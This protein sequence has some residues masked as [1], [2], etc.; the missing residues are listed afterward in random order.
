MLLTEISN[1]EI[2]KIFRNNQ[3]KKDYL[4][5]LFTLK[6]LGTPLKRNFDQ[7]IIDTWEYDI[8]KQVIRDM[9]KE[10]D[11]YQRCLE[12]KVLLDDAL[13]EW[14][15]LDLGT[16]EWPFA[17]A[18]FDGHVHSLNRNTELSELE[19]DEVLKSEIVKF[20]RIKKISELRN[21][22]IEYLIFQNEN[23]IP[24]FGNNR[25]VD[26]FING[27]PFDQKVAKSVGRVFIETQ[28]DNY[29]SIA[30][31]HPELVAKSLYE[32]Q[33]E[34]RFGKE[35]RL[36][37]VYLDTDMTTDQIKEQLENVDFTTP[38]NIDFSYYHSSGDGNPTNY[39]TECFIVLLHH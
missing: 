17:A 32:N 28:G 30:L 7:Q 36:L 37:I 10:T 25:G 19:K 12:C 27:K 26:F 34:D 18:A 1:V 2:K 5:R 33:D 9:F 24:T 3:N 38:L 31:S 22:Y 35:P 14:Q 8:S 15:N 16:L 21:D 39:N 11:K 23:V 13:S 20:R 4:E 29:R 6:K